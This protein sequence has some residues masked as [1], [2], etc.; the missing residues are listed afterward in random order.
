VALLKE[1]AV[2]STPRRQRNAVERNSLRSLA[3]AGP[4]LEINPALGTS[5]FCGSML[6]LVGGRTFVFSQLKKS[7]DIDGALLPW[8][9][10]AFLKFGL[11]PA[12]EI[13]R[14]GVCDVFFS[15]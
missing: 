12:A 11:P 2:V 4:R 1:S 10:Q 15:M 6:A 13:A 14:S 3:G 9:R 8:T 7:P 5:D